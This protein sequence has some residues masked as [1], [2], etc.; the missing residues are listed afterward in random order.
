MIRYYQSSFVPIRGIVFAERASLSFGRYN[1]YRWDADYATI[2]FRIRLGPYV[3]V[4]V[5]WDKD[6]PR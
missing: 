4:F 6:D 3:L 1:D 2:R 5:T